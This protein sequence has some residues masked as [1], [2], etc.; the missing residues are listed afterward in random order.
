MD[1]TLEQLGIGAFASAI[2]ECASDPS[3][4]SFITEEDLVSEDLGN[5]ALSKAQAK[6]V[7][8]KLKQLKDSKPR[9]VLIRR[10]Q[11]NS[12]PQQKSKPIQKPE[13]V[14]KFTPAT[15]LR[16]E[17][18]IASEKLEKEISELDQKLRELG[19]T[20]YATVIKA[21]ASEVS[22]LPYVTVDDLMS[23]QKA[24]VEPL[25]KAQASL[26]VKKC[27]PKKKPLRTVVVKKT[28]P[29]KPVP[30]TAEQKYP[31][32]KTPK[33]S[34][35]FLTPKPVNVKSSRSSL[36]KV[37]PSRIISLSG[38][39]LLRSTNTFVP[40]PVGSK[41]YAIDKAIKNL[42]LGRYASVV[43][44]CAS[45]IDTLR[46]ITIADLTSRSLKA[47]PLTQQQATFVVN[48]LRHFTGL[49]ENKDP[50]SGKQWE[51]ETLIGDLD[52]LEIIERQAE[53][54]DILSCLA[55]I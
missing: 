17:I 14:Q 20:D 41:D 16:K 24:G 5:D 49:D 40:S 27:T 38:K 12:T 55:S 50:N 31:T 8:R 7:I 21:C 11:N 28:T 25:S 6:L 22:T 42:Q 37:T 35:V 4:L 45:G 10:A 34:L 44:E 13:A 36:K 29:F 18:S 33:K 39:K 3:T 52:N 19:L 32:R 51:D 48:K 46:Y 53:A 43:K 2:K 54:N 15:K 47:T 30:I 26:V 9:R 23:P 1:A